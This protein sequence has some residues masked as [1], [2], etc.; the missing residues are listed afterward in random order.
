MLLFVYTVRHP[1]NAIALTNGNIWR[2]W[3]I[4]FAERGGDLPRTFPA[5]R[6]R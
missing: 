1:A 3:R 4:G 5:L 6:G 2:F